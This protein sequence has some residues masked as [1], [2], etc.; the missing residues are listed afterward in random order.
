MS[1]NT[2]YLGKVGRSVPLKKAFSS[3]VYVVLSQ[4]SQSSGES[5]VPNSSSSSSGQ[6]QSFTSLCRQPPRWWRSLGQ[7]AHW[8]SP[9]QPDCMVIQVQCPMQL[10]WLICAS[11]MCK[12]SSCGCEGREKMFWRFFFRAG[13][14][15]FGG[16]RFAFRAVQFFCGL[17]LC[18]RHVECWTCC[19]KSSEVD[20]K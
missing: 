5:S 11:R 12:I 6:E 9:V 8:E 1:G 2:A 19:F 14:N 4:S 16:G 15:R 10:S 20:L 17:S 18:W 13:L 7:Q 3:T